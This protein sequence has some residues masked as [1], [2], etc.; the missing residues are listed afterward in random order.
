MAA[1]AR[2]LLLLLA[3]QTLIFF[4]VLYFERGNLR[5]K[6]RAEWEA[7]EGTRIDWATYLERETRTA[8]R[9]LKRILILWVY[10]FPLTVFCALVYFVNFA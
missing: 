1:L 2:L 9:R 7:L 10:I 8:D 6:A 3:V 4:V 5:A